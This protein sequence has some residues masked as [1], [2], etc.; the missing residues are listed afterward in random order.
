[1]PQFFLHLRDDAGELLD[2]D[3]AELADTAAVE[4]C[5]MEAARGV[6]SGDL[7]NGLLDLRYRIDVENER[8]DIV[9]T[10]HFRDAVS[11]I[12]F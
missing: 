6:M 1:M 11:I 2:P 8:R 10:L 4:R 12:E 5:A 7:A 9:H 3:G